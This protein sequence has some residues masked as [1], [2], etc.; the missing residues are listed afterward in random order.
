MVH[1]IVVRLWFWAAVLRPLKHVV[2]LPVLVRLVHPRRA[3]AKHGSGLAGRLDA[4]FRASGPFPR[5]SPGNC[6]ERAFGAY[7]LLCLAGEHPEL[8]IGMRPSGPAGQ[9]DGHTWVVV[10]GRAIGED[11]RTLADFIR[12]AAFDAAGRLT[13]D[14]VPGPVGGGPDVA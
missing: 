9:V 11:D 14:A 13:T 5:R 4:L 6:L 2:P 3:T 12:V 1:S 8:V 7:R 10:D